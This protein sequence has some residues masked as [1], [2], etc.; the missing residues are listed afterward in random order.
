MGSVHPFLL[1]CYSVTKGNSLKLSSREGGE[2]I[3]T[4]C[5]RRADPCICSHNGTRAQVLSD[6]QSTTDFSS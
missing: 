2:E 5:T 1:D 4:I 3:V 6:T